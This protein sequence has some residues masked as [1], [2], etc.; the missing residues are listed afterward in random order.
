MYVTTAGRLR[1]TQRAA[2]RPARLVGLRPRRLPLVGAPWPLQDRSSGKD[3][4]LYFQAAMA[5]VSSKISSKGQVTVPQEIRRRLGVRAGDRV[6][7]AVEHGRV[8]LK[9]AR[10][11]EDP[12]A[13]YVGALGT[14][15]GGRREI[16]RWLRRLR[17][18]DGR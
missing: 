8:V 12:L 3:A 16:H 14:F 13:K 10:G 9:P 4:I 11:S 2:H 17:D 18:G 1:T 6:E 15:P 7:F 5:T